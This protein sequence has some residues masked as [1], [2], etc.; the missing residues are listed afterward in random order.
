[1]RIEAAIRTIH[2]IPNAWVRVAQVRLA[3]SGLQLD[4]TI[5]KEARGRKK[6]DEWTVGCRG[7]REVH[8][9]DFDGGGLAV[10]TRTGPVEQQYGARS[11]T[12]RWVNSGNVDS[13]LGALYRAHLD[14]V[15]DWI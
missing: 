3:P 12:L 10:Y 11:A 1:M 9:T 8:I 6:L 15:D 5:H 2:A 14:A 4:L 13:A 7:L